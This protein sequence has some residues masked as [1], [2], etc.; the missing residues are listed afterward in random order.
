MKNKFTIIRSLLVMF[1]DL[2]F[3]LINFFFNITSIEF[4]GDKYAR[5]EDLFINR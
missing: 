4:P 1:I 2:L 5:A 3:Y